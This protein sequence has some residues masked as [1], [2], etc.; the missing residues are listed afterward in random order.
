ML[1]IFDCNNF[2]SPSGGGVR[3]Y[4]LEKLKY[5]KNAP[6]QYIFLMNDHV[7]HTE[8]INDTT[9]IEHIKVPKVMGN[10]EYRYLIFYK[11]YLKYFE[12]YKPDIVEVGSPYFMPGI[13]KK[14]I[15][16]LGLTTR[17]VGFWHA[18]F[19]VTYV[20]RF[21]IKY[22]DTL[23][24]FFEYR[25]WKYANRVYN[26]M[27]KT[28]VSSETIQDRMIEHGINNTVF[29]PLGVDTQ[30]FSPQ[31]RS[32]SFIKPIK[33]FK[34]QLTMFF[35]HRFSDEK[36]LTSLI[37][38]YPLLTAKLQHEPAL[39]F[40]GTGPGLNK[41]NEMVRR[42]QHVHYVGFIK[43]PLDMAK[44]FSSV[45]IGF[46]LSGWETFGLSLV[47]SLSSGLP[48]VAAPTGAAREHIEKSGAGIVLKDISPETLAEGIYQLS[49]S[50]DLPDMRIKA[51]TYAEKLSWE[52]C[53]HKQLSQYK[54]LIH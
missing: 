21:F 31:H 17:V 39:V 42:H 50:P 22:S 24:D 12:K 54:E 5:F 34:S 13:V 45:D 10:W 37:K 11:A 52:S 7:E 16:K 40:A 14:C 26:S 32:T 43:D 8:T 3:R 27:S 29:L 47:E 33:A 15:K 53:F 41:V 1:T 9:I 30:L 38:A 28:F 20:R 51:R 18:D 4:H 48:L 23:A 44:W 49:K 46:A 2:W 6:V 35:P 25:S 36:G 19:P